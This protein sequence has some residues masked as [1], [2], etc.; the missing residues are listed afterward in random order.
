MA[1]IK[2]TDDTICWKNLD[3]L[4]FPYTAG[5]SVIWYKHIETLS[6]STTAKYIDILWSRN[7]TLTYMP[8]KMHLFLHQKRDV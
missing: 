4:E 3:K 7:S 5:E 1:K 6:I 2:K 8:S